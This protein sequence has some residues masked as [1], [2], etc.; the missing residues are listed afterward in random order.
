MIYPQLKSLGTIQIH[1]D[2]DSLS[3]M[4]TIDHPQPNEPTASLQTP[5]NAYLLMQM[6]IFLCLQSAAVRPLV[7]VI[8]CSLP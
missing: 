3:S 8:T 7:L 5:A 6:P 1:K 2:Q 4:Y